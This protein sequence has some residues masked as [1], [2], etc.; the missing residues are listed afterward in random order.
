MKIQTCIATILM[1]ALV[2]FACDQ[3]LKKVYVE[4][5]EVVPGFP[6]GE[7]YLLV[8]GNLPS[9][10]YEFDHSD[11]EVDSIRSVIHITP[12]A[13]FDA[14]KTTTQVLVPF[15]D[16]VSIKLPAG[17]YEVRLHG[18]KKTIKKTIEV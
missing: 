3:N 13:R 17:S 7:T 9:P 2:F 8:R 15:E 10:A 4:S 6:T 18:R 12:K 14:K 5:V 1:I 16:V 11:V